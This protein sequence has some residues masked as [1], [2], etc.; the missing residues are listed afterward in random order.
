MRKLFIHYLR[1]LGIWD[2]Q[3]QTRSNSKVCLIILRPSP[4]TVRLWGQAKEQSI[5]NKESRC[6]KSVENAKLITRR[7]FGKF[8][9]PGVF[10]LCTHL[11]L[12]LRRPSGISS[13]T[14]KVSRLLSFNCIIFGI[15]KIRILLHNPDSHALLDS[16]LNFAEFSVS[17]TIS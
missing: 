4:I 2:K 10:H 9:F 7:S 14:L 6:Y 17:I 11:F 12:L 3:E 8:H 13:R 1:I 16:I 15:Y 5:P